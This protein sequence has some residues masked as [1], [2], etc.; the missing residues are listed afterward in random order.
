MRGRRRRAVVALAAAACLLTLPA[1]AIGQHVS[2]ETSGVEVHASPGLEELAR[3][4]AADERAWAP[5]PAIGPPLA[6]LPGPPTVW[7]VDDL[8]AVP[9]RAPA[10][11]A[12]WVAGFAD[13]RRN[14]VAVRTSRRAGLAAVR[15]TFRHELAHLALDA[16]TE[17]RAP[18]WLHEGYAQMVTGEWDWRQAW[19]MRWALAD[20]GDMLRRLDLD[21]GRRAPEARLSYRLSYT[22]V[23][24]MVRMGGME[25]FASFLERL[26]AGDDV[27]A[28]M[29]STY[30]LTRA[31]FE[32]RWRRSV[33]D[34][35]GW[36][37][38]L[39]RAAFFWLALTV[40]VLLLGW[41]R[42]KYQRE[43]LEEMKR[44]ERLEEDRPAPGEV[45]PPVPDSS[46]P[47]GHGRDGQH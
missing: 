12:D 29:R 41:R 39:S 20:E 40:A 21:F 6:V 8:S 26:G 37:F 34:R 24:E 19:Q 25:G 15:R 14:L 35:Y 33:T 23:Q 1:P 43:R 4:L 17:G 44:R 2:A 47:R 28:A 22:V 31:Q 5:L 38:L 27:D 45:P 16:V 3:E 36:L 10:G 46:G 18:R 30:G 42:W 9:G 13:S 32:R 11:G 7:V